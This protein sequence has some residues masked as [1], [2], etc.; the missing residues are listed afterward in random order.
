[1]S[2]KYSKSDKYMKNFITLCY[3]RQAVSGYL[4]VCIFPIFHVVVSATSTFDQICQAY[5]HSISASTVCMN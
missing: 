3:R 1:M 4:H 5:A 2:A